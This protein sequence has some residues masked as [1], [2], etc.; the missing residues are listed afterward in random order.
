MNLQ[1]QDSKPTI[2]NH[3][4]IWFHNNSIKLLEMLY[5]THLL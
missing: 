1:K 2:S 4:I 3:F 5:G